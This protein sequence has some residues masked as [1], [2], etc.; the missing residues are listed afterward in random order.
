MPARWNA[1]GR[2]R[3]SWSDDEFTRPRQDVVSLADELRKRAKEAAQ[4]A[5]QAKSAEERD[6]QLKIQKVLEELAEIE[7]WLERKRTEQK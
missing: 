5:K 2:K 7:D 4:L 6:I 3:L 1:V